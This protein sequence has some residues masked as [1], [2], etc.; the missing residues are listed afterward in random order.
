[1][2]SPLNATIEQGVG[3]V[4]HRNGRDYTSVTTNISA[5]RG[6]GLE[7]WTA[8]EVARYTAQHPDE[9][10]QLVEEKGWVAAY[11]WLRGIPARHADE[12]ARVG[13][14]VHEAV[15]Q[16]IYA[17]QP[18]SVAEELAPYLRQWRRFVAAYQP[19][20]LHSEVTVYSN[21]YGYAGSLDLI[22]RIDGFGVGLVD[23]K[24]GD[25]LHGHDI[26]MQLA[27]YA[28]A[29]YMAIDDEAFP[30]P[31][32]DWHGVLHLRS[33]YYELVEID[34]GREAFLAFLATQQI[35]TWRI[36]HAHKTLGR[37]AAPAVASHP[38]DPFAGL[39]GTA[40]TTQAEGAAWTS[41]TY[42]EAQ[43]LRDTLAGNLARRPHTKQGL[44][45]CGRCGRD[46]LGGDGH[47][48]PTCRRTRNVEGGPA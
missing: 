46:T 45:A 19:E 36:R 39:D 44:Y 1:M 32:F 20:I 33:D 4:Y 9:V 22:C 37:V 3:R 34:A 14:D 27:G 41:L 13:T 42:G 28:N 6:S 25:S 35:A 47:H 23:I 29:D 7:Q 18:I 10:A 43:K 12:A 31:R 21:T 26:A 5:S 38:D 30:L 8:S 17:G 40:H 15:A 16:E 24:T 11:Y 2:T 48:C